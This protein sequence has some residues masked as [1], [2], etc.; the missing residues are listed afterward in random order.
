MSLMH[1]HVWDISAM[2]E[3]V[4]WEPGRQVTQPVI[5]TAERQWA[6]TGYGQMHRSDE[7]SVGVQQNAAR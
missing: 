7:E 2:S 5:V 4:A 3:M 6:G 1:R